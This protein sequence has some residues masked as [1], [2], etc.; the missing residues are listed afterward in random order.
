MVTTEGMGVMVTTGEGVV[1]VTTVEGRGCHGND[2]GRE[3]LFATTG[4]CW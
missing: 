4:G 3:G 2:W 1:M